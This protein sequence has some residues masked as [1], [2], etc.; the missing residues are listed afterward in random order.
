LSWL[1]GNQKKKRKVLTVK[2]LCL[3]T[4]RIFFV[5]K[6]KDIA[7]F[8]DGFFRMVCGCFIGENETKIFV[9]CFSWLQ[10]NRKMLLV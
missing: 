7:G 9:E 4:G 2:L 6:L 3:R 10:G 1:Q 8:V 5:A